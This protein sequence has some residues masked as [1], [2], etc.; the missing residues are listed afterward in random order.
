MSL[1]FDRFGGF[2]RPI[3]LSAGHWASR[4]G[5]R[6]AALAGSRRDALRA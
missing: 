3:R 2:P 5:M 4:L 1:A 6:A